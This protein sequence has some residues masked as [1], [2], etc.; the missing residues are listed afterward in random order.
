MALTALAQRS[1]RASQRARW[2]IV[3]LGMFGAA[4]FFGDGVITPAISVLGAVEGLEVLAPALSHWVVPISRGDRVPAVRVP[5]SR[6]RQGRRGVRAGDAGVVHRAGRARRVAD[7]CSIRGVLRAISPCYAV[8]FFHTSTGAAFFALGAVVLCITGAEALYADMGH[9]GKRPI[10]WSWF[11]LVLPALV[12]NY[13][14]Q[15]A[16]LMRQSAAGRESVLSDGALVAADPDDRAGHR[17]RRDRVAGGHFRRVLG[18]A[19]G[20]PAR[21]SAAHGSAPHLAR[22]ARADLSAVDQP[23]AA[24]ADAGGRDRFPHRRTTSAP[25]TASP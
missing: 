2:W 16:L 6:H 5:E 24:G 25:R 13:F 11:G 21:L 9:F 19:R 4:L 14:G 10:R 22:N 12:L 20:D 1:V 8:E 23:H 7:R 18:D 3:V 15:G 17:R